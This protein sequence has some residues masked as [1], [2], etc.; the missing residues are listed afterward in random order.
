M[1]ATSLNSDHQDEKTNV[2]AMM[3]GVSFARMELISSEPM[4]GTRKIC[5]VTRRP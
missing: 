4:P 2:M 1:S 5:S 3:T